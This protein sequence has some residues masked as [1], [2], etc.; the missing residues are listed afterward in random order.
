MDVGVGLFGH[1]LGERWIPLL[2]FNEDDFGMMREYELDIHV[3]RRGSVKV[4]DRL[5]LGRGSL[6]MGKE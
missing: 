3:S 6:V 5:V 2:G 1:G 4:W